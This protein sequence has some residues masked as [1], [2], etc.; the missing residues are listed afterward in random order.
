MLSILPL[1]APPESS[2]LSAGLPTSS[3]DK[4]VVSVCF[5]VYHREQKSKHFSSRVKE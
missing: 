4:L 5:E 1:P 3:E 2:R